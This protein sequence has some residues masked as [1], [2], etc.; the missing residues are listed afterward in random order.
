MTPSRGHVETTLYLYSSAEIIKHHFP[1]LGTYFSQF[2]LHVGMTPLNV[3]QALPYIT[4]NT[5]NTTSV[6]YVESLRDLQCLVTLNNGELVA[7]SGQRLPL[8]MG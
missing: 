4:I 7:C 2:H 1:L 5:I 3:R 8:I 6:G